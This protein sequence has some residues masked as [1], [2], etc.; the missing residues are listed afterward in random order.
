MSVKG[1][2]NPWRWFLVL[3]WEDS[4]AVL[5]IH[6]N[7][8]F[9]YLLKKSFRWR[10]MSGGS[11]VSRLKGGSTSD[12]GVFVL[13]WNLHL[14]KKIIISF[15]TRATPLLTSGRNWRSSKSNRFKELLP[16]SQQTTVHTHTQY[17]LFSTCNHARVRPV[18]QE[19]SSG[20]E[21][22]V[23]CT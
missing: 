16:L 9:I 4:S 12:S 21:L 7:V 14:K 11:T 13:L 19:L 6:I 18:F 15:R 20:C 22:T 17:T 2:L 23:V 1:H 10:G 5:H 8:L 3:Q